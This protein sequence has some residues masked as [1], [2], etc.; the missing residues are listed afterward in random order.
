VQNIHNELQ[1]SA[2]IYG[3][4]GNPDASIYRQAMA[5]LQQPNGVP[6]DTLQKLKNAAA[7]KA[8]DEFNNIKND[9][10]FNVFKTYSEAMESLAS[11]HP[12]YKDLKQTYSTLRSFQNGFERQ[13]QVEQARGAQTKG[14]GMMGRIGG[15]ITGG[16]VPATLGAAAVLAPIHP[17]WAASLATTIGGNPAAMQGAARTAAKYA[18]QGINAAKQGLIDYMNSTYGG[19]NA[20]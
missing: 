2:S 1:N 16:N 9:A 3:P 8:F 17:I 20:Q 14:I 6:F 18:P 7:A 13:L 19:Q 10:A 15:A 5:N 4:E 11:D 12:E